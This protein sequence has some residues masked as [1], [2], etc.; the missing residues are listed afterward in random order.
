[1]TADLRKPRK[2]IPAKIEVY[3][4]IEVFL[5]QIPYPLSLQNGG[6]HIMFTISIYYPPPQLL[7]MQFPCDIT[8]FANIP[9]VYLTR[10]MQSIV[11]PASG[12]NM[13]VC[14]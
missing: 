6:L 13:R 7:D 1:M 12:S 2:F 9:S 10:Q 14:L 3:M 4:I 5:I 8:R 11:R